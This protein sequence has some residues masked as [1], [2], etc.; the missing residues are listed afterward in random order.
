MKILITGG[1][2][3]IGTN[4]LEY[5]KDKNFDVFNVD[6]EKPRNDNHVNYW[7]KIDICDFESLN[8]YIIQ[9]NPDYI[10]HLAARTDLNENN[11]LEYY[12]ANIDGVRNLTKI[13]SN[14]KNIKRVIFASSMLVNEVG[15][16]PKNLFDYNPTTLYGESKVLTEKIIFEYKAT[17]PSFCIIR[18]TSI[19]GEWFAEPYKNFFDYVLSNKFFHPGNKACT[20]TYG[21]V[22]NSIYQIEK[23]LFLDKKNIDKRVFYI[24]DKPPINISEWANEIAKE[25]S[26]AKPKIIPYFIFKIVAYI[27]DILTVL[28]IKFPMTSFRLRNMTTNHIVNLDNT[29]EVC[30][31][32]PYDRTI[33]V[34]RTLIWMEDK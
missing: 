10:V 9:I 14:L 13:I 4:L 16:M 30:G 18:P 8:E 3:F 21:Y 23:L 5:F 22:G 6:I 31:N 33:A 1:S 26:L 19:W 20:K 25:A 34:K 32:I 12:S 2:G 27:G 28:G 29:Y 17:L 15:Y 11:G 7:K 24:G